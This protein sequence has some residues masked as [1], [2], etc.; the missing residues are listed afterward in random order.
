[1]SPGDHKMKER[2]QES[3]NRENLAIKAMIF[4]FRTEKDN[5]KSGEYPPKLPMRSSQGICALPTLSF[6]CYH[7]LGLGLMRR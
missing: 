2:R 4:G 6:V 5:D 7:R 3:L 1:M